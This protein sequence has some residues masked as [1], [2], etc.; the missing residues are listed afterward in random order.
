MA[1]PGPLVDQAIRMRRTDWDHPGGIQD[2]ADELYL[3]FLQDEA[4][5]TSVIQQPATVEDAAPPPGTMTDPFPE[6]EDNPTEFESDDPNNPT[7]TSQ[8]VW[9]RMMVPGMVVGGGGSTYT[10]EIY[11]NGFFTTPQT[12]RTV[13]GV[14]Q[15]QIA[16]DATIPSG[17]FVWVFRA[18]KQQVTVT[19][20]SQGRS[21]TQTRDIEVHYEMLV[22]V[23]L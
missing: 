7:T 15:L 21:E 17:T 16:A 19:V 10:V 9:S 5:G 11:P 18:A 1:T 12:K 20:D 4:G 2:M 8:R 23:W 6:N 3:I 14:R 22:P 13:S